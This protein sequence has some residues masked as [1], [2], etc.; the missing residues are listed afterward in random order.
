MSKLANLD[1]TALNLSG[2]NYLQW[3]L[4]TKIN[5][6][7]K[8]LGDTIAVENKESDK[9]RYK[10]ISIIRHHLVEGLKN[11][12]LTMEN[13][14][15]LWTALQRRY[16][17]QKTVL[18]PKVQDDW[19]NLR[20]MDFKSVDEY[21]SALFR[22]VSL[23]RLCGEEVTEHML[24][25]KTYS[26]F[27]SSNQILQ[28]Q[29][30][31]KGYDTYTELISCLLLAEAN[32]ELL[33]RNN[34]SRPAG[35][36]AIPEAHKVEPEVPKEANYVQND[37]RPQGRGRGAYRG[38]SGRDNTPYDR[39]PGNHNNRGR[40][41]S[42]GRGRGSYG[43]GRGGTSRPSYSTKSVC[44]RCGSNNHW[45][46][47]CRTPKHLCDLYQESMKNKNPEAHMVDDSGY[48]ADDD[49]SEHGLVEMD[50]ETSDCLKD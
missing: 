48:G 33:M 14:L 30:R 37:K 8:G 41:S 32:N 18:L 22:I 42:Y 34:A 44:H 16:D 21:N 11:Q 27:H 28:Q 24:L 45:V 17:H 50:Y 20:F 5:L 25:E 6:R 31:T 13:P 1:Y 23:M 4:D 9:D 10:A 7:S 43:R 40:G 38:R 35:S 19:K 39:K 3:A 15:D 49:D 2:D 46:K 29:Y 47:Q 26:T 36:S 12:Y